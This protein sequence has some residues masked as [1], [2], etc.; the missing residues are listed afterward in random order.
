MILTQASS[1]LSSSSPFNINLPYT[2][3]ADTTERHLEIIIIHTI[4]L[5]KRLPA[6]SIPSSQPFIP[7]LANRGSSIQY[8]SG[9]PNC[10]L[11]T[12]ILYGRPKS[13]T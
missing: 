9:R 3:F 12:S 8:L 13:L 6:S 5:Q 2:Y 4:R 7:P 11:S 10:K 1:F